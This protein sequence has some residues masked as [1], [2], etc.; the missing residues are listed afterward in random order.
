M[1]KPS[2][3]LQ[4]APFYRNGYGYY[5]CCE[6]SRKNS[7]QPAVSINISLE[8]MFAAIYR[9]LTRTLTL[10]RKH[11]KPSRVLI[12]IAPEFGVIIVQLDASNAY[13]NSDIVQRGLRRVPTGTQK[14][15][16]GTI[17]PASAVRSKA[18][19]VTLAPGPRGHS[20]NTRA[21][22]SV[23][24]LLFTH[25]ERGAAFFMPAASLFYNTPGIT[26]LLVLPM[27]PIAV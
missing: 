24:C 9:T 17:V 26:R 8:S 22:A 1:G 14:T 4:R 21:S 12:A 16:T 23:R 6:Y 10:P 18:V 15:R 19:P 13:R 7:I 27:A 2:S 25:E 20:Q 5:C 3:R 11:I